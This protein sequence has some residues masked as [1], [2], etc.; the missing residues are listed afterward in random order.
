M[1]GT[2][3]SEVYG[4]GQQQSYSTKTKLVSGVLH[5]SK[6]RWSEDFDTH[7][8]A[9][10]QRPV[11]IASSGQNGYRRWEDWSEGCIGGEE[12][13]HQHDPRHFDVLVKDLRLEHGNSVQTPAAR[14]AT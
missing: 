1:K 3:H 14:H 8:H 2:G 10:A 4:S 7:G 6:E 11:L 9:K 13:V 12:F 5:R